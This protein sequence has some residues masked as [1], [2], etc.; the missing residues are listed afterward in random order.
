MGEQSKIWIKPG[1]YGF[2]RE[3]NKEHIQWPDSVKDSEEL[4]QKLREE[5]IYFEVELLDWI[6]RSDILGDGNLMKTYEIISKGYDRCGENDD[7]YVDYTISKLN[8]KSEETILETGIDELI[9]MK[10]HR[11]WSIEH[12]ES[13][14]TYTMGKI[15]KSMKLDEKSFVVVRYDW[16]VENDKKV[17]QKYELTENTRLKYHIFFKKMVKVEDFYNNGTVFRKVIK[18]GEGT[19]SP[20]GDSTVYLKTLKQE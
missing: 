8:E 5:E 18:R 16:L 15:L 10:D 3:K 19:A 1:E 6:I 20:F 9:S 12:N 11:H 14:F 17:I 7:V 4:K 2:A 13:K